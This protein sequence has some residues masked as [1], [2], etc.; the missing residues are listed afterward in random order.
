M[1]TN[2]RTNERTYFNGYARNI[3]FPQKNIKTKANSNNIIK[4]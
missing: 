4:E 3:F 1:K 2:L